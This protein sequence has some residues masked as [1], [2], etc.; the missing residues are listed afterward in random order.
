MQIGVEASRAVGNKRVFV[1]DDDEITRAVLQFMLQDENEAHD[2]PS[3]D[4][5]LRKA[6]DWPPDLVLLGLSIVQADP[7]VLAEIGQHLS[8]TRVVLVAEAGQAAEAQR[9]VGHGAQGLLSKPLTVE[10]V[11]RTVDGMLGLLKAPLIQ[12]QVL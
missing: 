4:A 7:Q 8:G 9:W 2:L 6:Q 10:G 5:A 11:R 1:I 12:L 3:V